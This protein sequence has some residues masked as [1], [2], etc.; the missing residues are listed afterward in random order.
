MTTEKLHFKTSSGIKSIVGKDLITDKFVAIFELVKNSYDAG[1]KQVTITF[2][3]DRIII[4]D[5]G[6]G[7]SKQDLVEKWLNLA[8][9]DKKEGRNNN[10][11]A[12]VGSKGIGRFSADRLGRK[13]KITTKIKGES[14]LHKLLV[15]WEKFD[16]DLKKLFEKVELDYSFDKNLAEVELS[17]TKIEI[18]D[19]NEVWT[20]SEINKA[21]ESLKRLKNP[22]VK[23][24][25][26]KI[27][28]IDKNEL[29]ESEEIIESNIA[30]VLKDKSITI[31]GEF[32][33]KI[34]IKLYDRGEKIYE[35]ET[36]NNSIIKDV[37]IFIAINYL[38]TS[39]KMTF[40]KRM[41]IAPV[42]YG[43]LFIYK[44]KFRVMPYG[45][46]DFDTFG[47]NM[48]KTQGYSRYL[49]HREILGY[50]DIKDFNNSFFKEASSRDSG[51]VNNI[52]FEELR[53]LYLDYIHKPLEAFI[54]LVSWGEFR[55]EVDDIL[56]SKYFDDAD[57]NEVEKFKAYVSKNKTI[58][59]FKNDLN[60]DENN[61][62]K[63]IE[64]I[65]KIAKDKSFFEIEKDAKYVG[66]KL[67]QI[68]KENTEKQKD[69]IGKIKN[70]QYLESQNK[71]LIKSKRPAESYTEQISHHLTDISSRLSGDIKGLRRIYRD[72]GDEFKEDLIKV[73]NNLQGY[74]YE[75]KDFR[76]IL[77][78]TN[79]D[80]MSEVSS[81]NWYEVGQ[82]F[83]SRKPEN[84]T[85]K[86]VISKLSNSLTKWERN[87]RVLDLTMFFENFYKNSKQNGAQFLNIE[88][89][90][91][92][93]IFSN[94]SNSIDEE[95]LNKIFE[96]GFSTRKNG[97]GV[98]LYQVK[99][100][101][102]SQ[103]LEINVKNI[104]GL[105]VFEIF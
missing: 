91:N 69:I 89:F 90:E 92:R 37:P 105:V 40:S 80:M 38:T 60:Y 11:R 8:Y 10:D 43:N 86:V 56:K 73:I 79:Y 39:A 3:R 63:K 59:Y 83:Y 17:Y 48:R 102:R 87:T 33:E 74:Y 82:W 95:Y 53:S 76:A 35:V 42:N 29:V 36:D 65:E 1:A 66:K 6:H 81:L 72:V 24:D 23:D 47:L 51:F 46:M 70:I 98:G 50:M 101:L 77:E 16:V 62:Q 75:F 9:S 32:S 64:K 2:E 22:F 85:Y 18:L 28:V 7:M 49:G 54:H 30:E 5:N 57:I 26:F 31:E 67:L 103:N 61:P 12:F 94:N 44:N 20:I 104:D 15:D 93:I 34:S 58:K 19:L 100:F 14:N 25:G 84:D 68:K 45:E 52:Y 4:W 55:D 13:L 96:L 99:E 88:F 27:L 78:E 41:K 21:K 71:N 97:T